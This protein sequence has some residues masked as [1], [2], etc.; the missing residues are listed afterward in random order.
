MVLDRNGYSAEDPTRAVCESGS[1]FVLRLSGCVEP[2]QHNV[3]VKLGVDHILLHTRKGQG[4]VEVVSP[5][6]DFNV[7]SHGNTKW[8]GL[9]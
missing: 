7:G 5:R 3:E 2:L 6:F 1:W 9:K 8:V 4:F